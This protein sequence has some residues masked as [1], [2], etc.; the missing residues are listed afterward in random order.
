MDVRKRIIFFLGFQTAALQ[1]LHPLRGCF[2]C[3]WEM[4]QSAR[5]LAAS[6]AF[7]NP[8]A[9]PTGPTAM[10]PPGYPFV[11]SLLIRA[12]GPGDGFFW[13]TI[14][15]SAAL[16][17]VYAVLLF[18]LA[19]RW[20]QDRRAAVAA[21]FFACLAPAFPFMPQWDTILTA[22]GLLAYLLYGAPGRPGVAWVGLGAAAGLLS[23]F[24]P[25]TLPAT[26]LRLLWTLPRTRAAALAAAGW[27]AGFLLAAGPWMARNH[28]LLGTWNLRT[29]FG[30]T[31]YVSNNGCASP[32]LLDSIR[33]GCYDRNHPN[34]NAREAALIASL[35]EAR[36]DARRTAD[37]LVWMRSNPGRTL[38][39]AA[40]RFVHFWFPPA[41]EQSPYAQAVW[42][43]TLLGAG[44]LALM[45][46][47]GLAA[48]P[49]LLA[50][51]VVLPLP[52]YF[53]VSDI[54]YRAPILFASQLAA[55]SL[56]AEAWRRLEAWRARRAAA[57]QP[58]C[59]P[60]RIPE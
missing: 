45:W 33:S 13:S 19:E 10:I 47:R 42:L 4:L 18:L 27:A 32:G 30:I 21:A 23:L 20:L 28:L 29:N 49:Y 50:L 40:A 51:C 6:G 31:L 43:A 52:Y 26:A 46:R 35:G 14:G 5:T 11:L 8:F 39:L 25:M 41:R 56:L 24:N 60:A 22:S 38:S 2:D 48:W 17:G 54:R 15:L 55:G 53:V 36:Y 34:Q 16:H 44:G 37:T 57:A 7:A 3:G 12:A 59:A 1:L 58:G 9:A